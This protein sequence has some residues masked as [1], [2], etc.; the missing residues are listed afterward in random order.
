MG[1]RRSIELNHVP[2]I[3]FKYGNEEYVAIVERSLV[4]GDEVAWSL[5]NGTRLAAENEQPLIGIVE[6]VGCKTLATENEPPE[7]KA[8]VQ[9]V[10]LHLTFKIIAIAVHFEF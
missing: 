5:P 8:V 1:T 2:K 9:F 3:G 4:V 7:V 10:R 6:F